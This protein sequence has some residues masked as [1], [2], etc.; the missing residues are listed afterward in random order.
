MFPTLSVQWPWTQPEFLSQGVFATA[1][2]PPF[3][4]SGTKEM[5]VAESGINS[6]DPFRQLNAQH[7]TG[8]DEE[9]VL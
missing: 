1:P 5:N 2:P 3:S 9:K 6:E 4:K 8:S 7:K